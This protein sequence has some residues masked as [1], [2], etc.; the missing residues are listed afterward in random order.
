MFSFV[1]FT[2][3]V[4]RLLDLLVRSTT[5][6]SMVAWLFVLLLPPILTLTLPMGVLVGTLIGLSR[7]GSDSEVT[8]TRASGLSVGVFVKPVAI[9]SLTGCA[10]GLYC[11]CWLGPRSVRELVR[12]ENTMRA[13]Q[14][15]A[16]VQPRVWEERFPNMVL[17]VNDVVSSNA[18]QWRGLFVA[19]FQSGAAKAGNEPPRQGPRIITAER[20]TTRPD[21]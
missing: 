19:D 8:A 2:R 10:L 13:L 3:D 20:A 1:L 9:L 7:M 16:E 11:A 12:I 5:T 4:G 15:S 17:Y 14:V 18:D 21:A 6:Q